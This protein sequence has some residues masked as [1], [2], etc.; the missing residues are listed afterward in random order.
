MENGMLRDVEDGWEGP[1]GIERKYE[2]VGLDI[3]TLPVTSEQ[4]CA[5]EVSPQLV[6]LRPCRASR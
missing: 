6:D 2:A 5:V 3:W 1:S 4:R